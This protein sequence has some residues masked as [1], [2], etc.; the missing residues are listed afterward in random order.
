[1]SRGSEHARRSIYRVF[2]TLAAI[3]IGLL[4]CGG[5]SLVAG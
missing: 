3:A 2:A 5:I 4:L 1:M